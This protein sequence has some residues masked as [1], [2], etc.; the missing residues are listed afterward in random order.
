MGAGEEME[1]QGSMSKPHCLFDGGFLGVL[2][3]SV[4]ESSA[5]EGAILKARNLM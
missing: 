2:V 1:D 4:L 5:T 3:S